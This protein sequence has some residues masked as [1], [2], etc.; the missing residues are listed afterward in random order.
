M[1]CHVYILGKINLSSDILAVRF[2]A[3][4]KY[5]SIFRILKK[6]T[7]KLI[8]L[9]SEKQLSCSNDTNCYQHFIPTINKTILF[10]KP[11]WVNIREYFDS[12]SNRGIQ[13]SPWEQAQIWGRIIVHCLL[14]FE[15]ILLHFCLLIL[16]SS[17]LSILSLR[18]LFQQCFIVCDDGIL[19]I[20]LSFYFF[21]F[22]LDTPLLTCLL[23]FCPWQELEL[24]KNKSIW[25]K[26]LNCKRE[27]EKLVTRREWTSQRSHGL[28][29]KQRIRIY[30]LLGRIS[31]GT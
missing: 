3:T 20:P 4:G 12:Q 7:T 2:Y 22:E 9:Y 11:S 5:S 1:F 17:I 25:K 24:S 16:T 31:L 30:L 8:I 26:D 13:S 27:S 6:K 14:A 23:I 19:I 29:F 21:S 18:H 28:H 15:F 10:M